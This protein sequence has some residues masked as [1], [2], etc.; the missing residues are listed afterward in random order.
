M[1]ILLNRIFGINNCCYRAMGNKGNIE[2][3]ECENTGKTVLFMLMCMVIAAVIL[4]PIV[5]RMEGERWIIDGFPLGWLADGM[6]YMGIFFHEIGHSIFYWLY[7][8]PSLP[9]FDMHCGGGMA[10]FFGDRQWFIFGVVS[11]VI[12]YGIWSLKEIPVLAFSLAGLLIFQ[13][14]TGFID[15]HDN[16][17]LFMGHGAEIIVGC[18]FLFRAWFNLAPKGITER[19]LNG[20]IGF[21]M[22]FN[23]ML[24]C[25]GLM[26]SDV[27]RLVYYK[28][29]GHFGFGDFSRIGDAMGIG[30][31]S[32]SMFCFVLAIVGIVIP[33][34]CYVVSRFRI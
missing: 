8:Y 31:E 30:I 1:N 17:I 13:L 5:G 7:G 2:S 34:I 24:M 29:K 4:L 15:F 18:F 12:L 32:I 19:V 10:Y 23:V 27:Q 26:T 33:I 21:G 20:V 6:A 14:A 22:I 9:S 28:Q 25:F 11:L 16:V 3:C